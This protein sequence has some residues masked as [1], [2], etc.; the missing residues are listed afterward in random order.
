MILHIGNG[1]TVRHRSIIGIFDLDNVTVKA[2]GRAFLSRATKAGRVTYADS[3]IPR[4]FLLC[5]G[6]R[7]DKAIRQNGTRVPR[8]EATV[9]LSHISSASLHSR[10][11]T[12]LHGDEE[13]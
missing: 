2:S 10:A 8:E 13:E 1:K 6:G 11:Q 4:S 12:L 5:D 9:I 7:R 3:D